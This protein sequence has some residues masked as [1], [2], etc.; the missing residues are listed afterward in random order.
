MKTPILL[1]GVLLAAVATWAQ[2]PSAKPAATPGTIAQQLNRELA[3]VEHDVVP[4]AEAMPEDK[5]NF[6]PSAAI[7]NFNGVRTFAQEVKHIAAA[8]YLIAGQILNQAP[9]V[10]YE[11]NGPANITSKADIVRFL[12]DSFAYAHKAFDT[13]TLE[14]ATLPLKPGARGTRL[15]EAADLPAHAND[16]YGQMV[17]YLRMN[18]LTPPSSAGSPPANPKK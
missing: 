1:T 5:Y 15:L 10:P 7:G 12:K 18:G 11:E 16:H 6:A 2:A 13:I 4:A 14:N 3:S 8:N 17:E 9:P